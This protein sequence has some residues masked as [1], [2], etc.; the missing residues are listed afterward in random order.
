MTVEEPPRAAEAPSAADRAFALLQ[1]LLP[2]HALSRAMHG[3]A[4]STRPAVRR[5]LI[6][7]VLRAYPT[8]DLREAVEPDPHA[9]PSFN[10]F[11]TRALRAGARTIA[12]GPDE[13]AA[14]V[15]GTVS[16]RGIVE[17]GQLLQAKGV[18]Y[19]VAALL[20]DSGATARYAGGAFACIYLA[21]HDYHRIHMPLAG[22]LD[23]TRYVPGDFFSVNAATTR[24]VPELFARNERVVCEFDTTLGPLAMVLVGALF[25]GSL[26]TVH[27]GE[28][29]PPGT[30]GGAVRRID[31]GLGTQFAKGAEL[32]RFNMGS[33]VIVVLGNRGV[34]FAERFVAGA[35]I[36]MGQPIA[37]VG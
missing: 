16:Q 5:N 34:R 36:R 24:T 30:R 11:F 1:S 2:R 32:G 15:D 25:V 19:T 18:R 27:A 3:V 31:A 13:V 20:A 33:T 7:F 4:R 28:I 21:P 22:R 6:R 14:P 35:T 10:A 9:Y 37:K 23:A 17:D 29:N 8:I 26:E 12:P